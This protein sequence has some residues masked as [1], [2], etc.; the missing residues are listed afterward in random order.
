MDLWKLKFE[1][2]SLR[3]GAKGKFDFAGKTSVRGGRETWRAGKICQKVFKT[4]T[5]SPNNR[6]V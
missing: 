5:S 3:F 1:L 4:S 2:H 6:E